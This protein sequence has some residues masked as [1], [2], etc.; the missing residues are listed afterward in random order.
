AHRSHLSRIIACGASVVSGGSRRMP[1]TI[2]LA[3]IVPCLGHVQACIGV[4]T[5]P[6]LQGRACSLSPYR[7]ALGALSLASP[8]SSVASRADIA[9]ALPRGR[10]C[11][12]R[13]PR[14]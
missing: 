4:G 10:L 13:G 7:R 2:S 1:E 12:L 3:N 6:R 9:F 8:A 11:R 5:L 14:D